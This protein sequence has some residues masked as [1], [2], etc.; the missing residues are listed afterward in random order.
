MFD[1][2]AYRCDRFYTYILNLF[3]LRYILE[4]IYMD[5]T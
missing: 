5:R 2:K 3:L 1:G 4:S